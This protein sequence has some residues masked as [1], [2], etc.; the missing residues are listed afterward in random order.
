MKNGQS[1]YTNVGTSYAYVIN[2]AL[3]ASMVS[4][5]KM[6]EKGQGIKGSL[7]TS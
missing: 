7:I 6:D 4:V 3:C 1:E 5:V 2:T